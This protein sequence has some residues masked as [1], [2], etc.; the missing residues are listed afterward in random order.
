MVAVTHS[1]QR[2]EFDHELEVQKSTRPGQPAE[3]QVVIWTRKAAEN[4]NNRSHLVLDFTL[5]TEKTA[6]GAVEICKTAVSQAP[7]GWLVQS[8]VAPSGR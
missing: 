2:G 1:D 7:I 3:S 4:G 6:V 8:C 5:A